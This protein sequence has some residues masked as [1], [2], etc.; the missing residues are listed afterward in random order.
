MRKELPGRRS[1]VRTRFPPAISSSNEFKAAGVGVGCRGTSQG[2]GV[3]V[4]LLPRPPLVTEASTTGA[5]LPAF[6]PQ[7]AKGGEAA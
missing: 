1:F 4:P 3:V 7:G 2:A 5:L 6:L